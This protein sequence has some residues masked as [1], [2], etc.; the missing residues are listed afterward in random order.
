MTE[1]EIVVPVVHMNG[2]AKSDLIEQQSEVYLQLSNVLDAMRAAAPNGRDY[3]PAPGLM[4]KAIAQHMR[5][6]GVITGLMD[7]IQQ[8]IEMINL[9]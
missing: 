3:Y 5:R 9:Q 4:E 2:T 8:Q 7:E 1:S 6:M